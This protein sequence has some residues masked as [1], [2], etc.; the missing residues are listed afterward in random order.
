MEAGGWNDVLGVPASN[1]DQSCA[2]CGAGRPPFAHRLDPAKVQFRAYGKG[3][4]L[5]TF[6]TVC[7]GCED[8][9][10]RRDDEGL[11]RRMRVY[12]EFEN[13]QYIATLLVTFR[14]SDLGP[15]PLADHR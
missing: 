14:A 12:H 9:V 15:C 7:D 11:L 10:A 2:F 1:R 8:L 4:T 6:W 3:H 13:E 5:P